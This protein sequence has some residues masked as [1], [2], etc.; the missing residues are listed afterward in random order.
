MEF[1]SRR[2]LRRCKLKG[3][4]FTFCDFTAFLPITSNYGVLTFLVL[5]LSLQTLF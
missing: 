4:K 1:R 5:G 3:R 2:K